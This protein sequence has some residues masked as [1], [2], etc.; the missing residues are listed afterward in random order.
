MTTVDDRAVAAS[1]YCQGYA[2]QHCVM[3]I[4]HAR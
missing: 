3:G 2:N 4:L 1:G